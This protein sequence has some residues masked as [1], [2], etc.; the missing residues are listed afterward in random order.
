MRRQA[1]ERRNALPLRY[2]DGGMQFLALET[3]AQHLVREEQSASAGGISDIEA[4]IPQEKDI[5]GVSDLL[6]DGF[7]RVIEPKL[8]KEEQFGP[9]A[10]LWNGVVVS[11]EREVV[12]IGLGQNLARVLIRPSI[13]KPPGRSFEGHGLGL[14]LVQ[15]NQLDSSPVAFCELC[16]LPNDG[17]K[18]DDTAE[19]MAMLSFEQLNAAA[20]PYLLNFCVAKGFRRKGVGRALLWLAED[21]VRNVWSRERLYLHADDDTA[22]TAFYTSAGYELVGSPKGEKGEPVH[23]CKQLAPQAEAAAEG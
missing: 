18:A 19:V 21:I 20:E 17:R 12:R 9:L 1:A 5:E 7:R 23:M 8:L 15:R 2:A 3:R 4:V 13:L 14:M 11:F 6:I 16:L 10:S 22:A